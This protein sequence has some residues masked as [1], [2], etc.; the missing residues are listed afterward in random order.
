MSRI[1]AEMRA[2]QTEMKAR[3]NKWQRVPVKRL[4]EASSADRPQRRA[5]GNPEPSSTG[6]PELSSSVS[7]QRCCSRCSA[8][9]SSGV[10]AAVKA[11][12]E[13]LDK[14]ASKED[15]VRVARAFTASDTEK[16]DQNEADEQREVNLGEKART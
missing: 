12:L 16:D 10:Y 3:A 11:L 6:R 8:S 9:R 1:D 15:R 14:N 13:T 7:P 5:T 4:A 2:I